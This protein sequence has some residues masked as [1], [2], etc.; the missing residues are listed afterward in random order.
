M[1][2]TINRISQL[3]KKLNI[4][5]RQFDLSIGAANGYTLR[6]QKNSASVGSD[7]IE[8]IIKQYPT[9]NLEW[10]IMGKGQMF[11]EEIDINENDIT[12]IIEKK[13][14]KRILSID[15]QKLLEEIKNEIEK[16]NKDRIKN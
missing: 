1:E 3:I 12:K 8:K 4:S 5:A 13:I 11:I 6:M 16:I 10:L 9:I 14:D 15:K 7:V 2:K